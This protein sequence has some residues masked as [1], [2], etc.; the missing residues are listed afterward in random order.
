MNSKEQTTEMAGL[1]WL[2]VWNGHCIN[3]ICILWC[4]WLNLESIKCEKI[5]RVGQ[6]QNQK[7]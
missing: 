3:K 1:G 5:D 2:S 7:C 4:Q 6:D